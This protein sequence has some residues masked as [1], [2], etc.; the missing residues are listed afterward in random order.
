MIVAGAVVLILA[1]IIACL[2]ALHQ[3]SSAG[4]QRSIRQS[5]VRLE[6]NEAMQRKDVDA[7]KR[8]IVLNAQDLD[9][10]V[11]KEVR[12][13][14]DDLIIEQDDDRMARIGTTR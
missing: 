5:N 1:V 13:V 8:I 9:K 2:Y 7:L 12:S 14:I 10:D 3:I 6:L 11:K 4:V